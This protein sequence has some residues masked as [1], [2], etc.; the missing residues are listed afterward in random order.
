MSALV[1]TLG[2]FLVGAGI[3]LAGVIVARVRWHRY[4]GRPR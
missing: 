4:T 3:V 1:A 2:G